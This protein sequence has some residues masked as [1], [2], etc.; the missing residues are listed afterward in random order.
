M[1]GTAAHAGS[2]FPAMLFCQGFS[3]SCDR[4]GSSVRAPHGAALFRAV[5]YCCK[6]GW[7]I[8]RWKK[9]NKKTKQTA[10]MQV[11]SKRVN[12]WEVYRCVTFSSRNVRR[13]QS[14]QLMNLNVSPM[15]SMVQ[16]PSPRTDHNRT[17]VRAVLH[18]PVNNACVTLRLN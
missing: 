18:S 1:G 15:S 9:Q 4:A 6:A 16:L 14:K 5:M 13:R 10:P 12:R 7:K 8:V 3:G 11:G 17:D 2:D